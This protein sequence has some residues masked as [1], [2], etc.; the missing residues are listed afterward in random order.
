MALGVPTF[1]QEGGGD[2]DC[3]IGPAP[4]AVPKYVVSLVQVSPGADDGKG[5][6]GV[7]RVL[8]APGHRHRPQGS[9]LLREIVSQIQGDAVPDFQ[10]AHGQKVRT[11][12]AHGLS[13]ICRGD[14][15]PFLADHPALCHTALGGHIVPV[16]HIEGVHIVVGYPDEFPQVC[17]FVRFQPV[18]RQI[19][20]VHEIWPPAN[21]AVVTYIEHVIVSAGVYVLQFLR[22]SNALIYCVVPKD[23]DVPV[24]GLKEVRI[25]MI[26]KI[27]CGKHVAPHE[28]IVLVIYP[29]LYSTV[30]FF[31][32]FQLYSVFIPLPLRYRVHKPGRVSGQQFNIVHN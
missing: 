9:V 23:H 1:R 13:R 4:V 29:I 27:L 17:K 20:D 12:H 11:H 24:A 16:H 28:G 31:Y 3:V 18:L 10:P 25:I 7:L 2:K 19:G 21:Q 22:R 32:N 30:F 15:P 6:R 8:P 26:Q 14:E 5:L